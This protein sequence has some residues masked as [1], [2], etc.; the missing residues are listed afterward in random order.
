M[1]SKFSPSSLIGFVGKSIL[2]GVM[3]RFII[4]EKF[5]KTAFKFEFE[6]F[7]NRITN[8]KKKTE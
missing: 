4:D 5:L 2:F 6:V 3:L 1:R 8:I 7:Y